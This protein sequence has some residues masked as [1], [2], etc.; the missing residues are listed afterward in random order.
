M[1]KPFPEILNNK[2]WHTTSLERYESII[3]TGSILRHPPL[4][5]SERHTSIDDPKYNPIVRQL[6]GISLFNFINFDPILYEKKF[7]CSTWYSFVP[8]YHQW[9]ICVWI[10]INRKAVTEHLILADQLK[11]I[12]YRDKIHGN[13]MPEIEVACLIDIRVEWFLNVLIYDESL[14]E[15]VKYK[16]S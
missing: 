10:E 11:E 15:F 6:E 5:D 16:N 14:D 9:K 12:A 13:R 8:C 1:A 7:P 2:L 3:E 4:D